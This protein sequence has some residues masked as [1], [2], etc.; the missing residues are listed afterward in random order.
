MSTKT[1]QTRAQISNGVQAFP[2]G[3]NFDLET[4]PKS[5]L[6][7]LKEQYIKSPNNFTGDMKFFLYSNKSSE[8]VQIPKTIAELSRLSLDELKNV[9][10]QLEI[11]GW[12]SAEKKLLIDRISIYLEVAKE[13]EKSTEKKGKPKLVAVDVPVSEAETDKGEFSVVIKREDFEILEETETTIKLIA[14]EEFLSLFPEM[15]GVKMG[16]EIEMEKE[17]F[18]AMFPA[19]LSSEQ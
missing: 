8:N 2:A 19:S 14:T 13:S 17:E 4:L 12:S 16:D 10:C 3:Y 15:E 9:A 6:K 7:F 5:I 1:I 18:E 11:R